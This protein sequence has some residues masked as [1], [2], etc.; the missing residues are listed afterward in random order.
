MKRTLSGK[1]AFEARGRRAQSM[2][3]PLTMR[4]K[5]WWPDWARTAYARGYVLNESIGKVTK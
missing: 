5:G 1:T 2:G 3:I 4:S